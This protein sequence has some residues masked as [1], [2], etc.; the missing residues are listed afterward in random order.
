MT[1]LLRHA[2]LAAALFAA[3]F[4]SRAAETATGTLVA[5]LP[6]IDW[7]VE[8]TAPGFEVRQDA[9]A[10]TGEGVRIVA[11][12][13]GRRIV[14]SVFLG[15]APAK[16]AAPEARDYYWSLLRQKPFRKE[17]VRFAEFGAMATVEYV[18]PEM[19][20]RKVDHL[21]RSAYMSKDPCWVE[22]QLTRNRDTTGTQEAFDEILRGVR[23]NE[24][25]RPSPYDDMRYG[26]VFFMRRDFKA[27]AARMRRAYEREKEPRTLDRETWVLLVDQLG[28]AELVGG[29][30]GAARTLCDEALKREPKVSVLY[31]NRA[32]SY[33]AEGNAA[34]A[35]KDLERA[36]ENRA[37]M[38][39][40]RKLADPAQDPLF[41]K[42]RGDAAFTAVAAK[43]R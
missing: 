25:Y 11:V 42:I 24:S 32:A 6:D 21:N 22:I 43:F 15:K 2:A 28:L 10:P 16:G 5:S 8:V 9:L 27:A 41:E 14:M 19:D 3:A 30:P 38:M 36:Y 31:Y 39:P 18:V 13:E 33:A 35:V 37:S 7:S 12:D 17:Q 29:N 34:E 20:G 40:G 1:R 26:S 23:F 4:P